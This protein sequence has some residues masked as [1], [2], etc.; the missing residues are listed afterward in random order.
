MLPVK[1]V[2]RRE[3]KNCYNRILGVRYYYYFVFYSWGGAAS[4]NCFLLNR[5]FGFGFIFIAPPLQYSDSPIAKL[6]MAWSV[7]YTE[8]D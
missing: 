3:K 6:H 4:P 2:L 8:I 5:D 7:T 1:A